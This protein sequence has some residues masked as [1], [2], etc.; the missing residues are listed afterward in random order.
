MKIGIRAHD[1]H[2]FDDPEGLAQALKKHGFNF[3]Q[4]APRV[5]LAGLTHQGAKLNFGLAN[6]VKQAFDRN[7]VTIAVLGCYWIEVNI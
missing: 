4:F 5:S 3:V 6:Q 1:I 7:G 2:I